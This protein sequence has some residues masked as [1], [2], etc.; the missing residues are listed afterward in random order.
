MDPTKDKCAE[1][2]AIREG[3]EETQL[4]LTVEEYIGSALVD[5]WRYRHERDKIMTFLY[6]MRYR[7]GTPVASDDIEYVT[8]ASLGDIDENTF[9][10]EHRPLWKLFQDWYCQL[11]AKRSEA[12][13][14]RG[15][16]KEGK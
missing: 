13:S 16:L 7:D 4:N 1:D 12:E 6:V 14:R 10:P 2:A 8:W 11:I 5:D 15:F 3:K 9:M